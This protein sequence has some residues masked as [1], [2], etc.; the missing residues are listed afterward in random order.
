MGKKAS[1]KVGVAMGLPT[2]TVDLIVFAQMVHDK[3][4]AGSKVLPTPSPALLVF[5]TDIDALK[6]EQVLV[7][8]RIP[9]AVNTRN[10][11]LSVVKLDLH[12]ERAYVESVV[13][14]DP[15]NAAQIAEAAGFSLYKSY[16]RSKLPL[17]VKAGAV[18]GGVQL[19]AKAALGAKANLWQLS[20]DGGKTWVDLPAT[21]KAKTQVANLTPGTIVQFRQRAVTKDGVGDWSLPVPQVVA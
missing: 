11:A 12:N 2:R 7:L 17:A 18:S 20:T 3:L 5:Q 9:G 6:T 21:T 14:A 1:S 13:N 10:Q 15:A 19:V 16:A 8:Q 4:A